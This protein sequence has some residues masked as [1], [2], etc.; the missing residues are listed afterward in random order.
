MRLRCRKG[1]YTVAEYVFSKGRVRAVREVTLR[2]SR[3]Q[4]H[5]LKPAFILLSIPQVCDQEA[6]HEE[7]PEN[8]EQTNRSDTR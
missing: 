1:A 3:W 4:P 7:E 6:E 5:A 8:D 2:Q